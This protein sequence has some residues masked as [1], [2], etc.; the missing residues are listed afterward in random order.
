M[1]KFSPKVCEL[2][3]PTEAAG[4]PVRI[5]DLTDALDRFLDPAK[6][7][8]MPEDIASTKKQI[9]AGDLVV[10]RLRSYLREIA[11]VL[12]SDGVPAVAS[13]EFIVLRPKKER[14]LAVEAVLIYLRSHLPQ[15]V[16]KWS[17]DGSNHPRSDER[18]L[19][20]LP[21]PRALIT[22]Q[23]T[24]QAAVR[25]M[26]TQRQRATRFLDAAKRAVE[27]AIEDSEAAALAHLAAANPPAVAV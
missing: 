19:L 1:N 5:Y 24:Y 10:S 27:I 17:R 8:T 15:I 9:A 23:A 26:V 7:S 18:E 3:Q 22:G 14:T 25:Q 12:P 4:S 11:I 13:T 6:L 2:W 20:N 21:V 16:F